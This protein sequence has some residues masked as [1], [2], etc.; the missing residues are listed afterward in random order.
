MSTQEFS[1]SDQV[2]IRDI[3]SGW[4]EKLKMNNSDLS[5]LIPFVELFCIFT[6]N[7]KNSK[8]LDVRNLQ[9]SFE[10]TIIDNTGPESVILVPIFNLI[11]QQTQIDQNTGRLR[12][13]SRGVAGI[14]SLSVSIANIDLNSYQATMKV[15]IPS[16]DDEIRVNKVLRRLTTVQ[17]D[18]TWIIMYG[19]AKEGRIPIFNPFESDSKTINLRKSHRGYYRALKCILIRYDW[20]IDQN[21]IA[22]GTLTFGSPIL[23]AMTTTVIQNHRY[24]IKNLLIKESQLKANCPQNI[25]KNLPLEVSIKQKREIPTGKNKKTK[26]EEIVGFYNLGWVIEAVRQSMEKDIPKNFKTLDFIKFKGDGKK[27]PINFNKDRNDQQVIINAKSPAEIPIE[28]GLVNK[29]I[30]DS[31][32]NKSLLQTVSDICNMA[33]QLWQGIDLDVTSLIANDGTSLIIGDLNQ[34]IFVNKN[35]TDKLDMTLAS[36]NS[37]INN[38]SFSGKIA[39]DLTFVLDTLISNDNG[40]TEI[41]NI[42]RKDAE[43]QNIKDKDLSVIALGIRNNPELYGSGKTLD[44]N[45]LRTWKQYLKNSNKSGQ[46]YNEIIASNEVPLGL[47]M[48]NYFLQIELT[49]HGTAAIPPYT[50]V[51]LSN[52]LPGIDGEYIIKETNDELG[53]GKFETILTCSLQEIDV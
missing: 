43:N 8:V 26:I 23:N 47:A 11:E 51:K 18:K 52:V 21:K 16:L 48:K 3:V 27:I 9:G 25:K 13:N 2:A 36:G 19:W 46:I 33:N 41:F 28:V 40:A 32:A 10:C 6:G 1:L 49:I 35:E 44:S 53:I 42:F 15:V 45:K 7:D 17:P 30:I 38:L 37:L 5:K 31:Q 24:D 34:T 29:T 22:R 39:K 50:F 4:N 20:E 12:N 14:E